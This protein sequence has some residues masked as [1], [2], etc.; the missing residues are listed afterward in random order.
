M[1]SKKLIRFII[2]FISIFPVVFESFLDWSPLTFFI[3]GLFISILTIVSYKFDKELFPTL[4][5]FSIVQLTRPLN[6]ELSNYLGV[7]FA[8]VLFLIPILLFTIIILLFSSIRKNMNWWN[9]EKKDYFSIYLAV[10][11]VFISSISLFIWAKYICADFSIYIEKFPQMEIKWVL[12]NGIGFA[13]LNS[14]AEEFIT[15]GMLC[16]GLE[17][18]I[19]NKKIILFIQ[20]LIFGIMHYYG[21][22]GGLIGVLMVFFWSI[23]LGILRYRT[24]GLK[25]VIIAHFFAD[26]T[27]YL[28]VYS[29]KY[30]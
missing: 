28:I 5:F 21:F 4:L 7:W 24:N 1:D 23:V 17:K 9:I 15:R 13:F 26:L 30:N 22:P 25:T 6:R 16:N 2:L 12:L 11:L 29:F 14:I 19:D 27:I 18:I 10:G 20:A 8:G 3:I